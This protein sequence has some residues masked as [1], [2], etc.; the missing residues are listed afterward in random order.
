MTVRRAVKATMVALV[1]TATLAA[2]PAAAG[3]ARTYKVKAEGSGIVSFQVSPL[4]FISISRMKN[5]AVGK[6]WLYSRTTEVEVTA[7]GTRSVGRSTFLS[8][9]GDQIFGTYTGF[10]PPPVGGVGTSEVQFTYT[11]GTG[12]FTGATGM[13]TGT[14]TS[15]A[16]QL[17][18]P[19]SPFGLAY[20][21]ARSHGYITY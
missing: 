6:G 4:E 2:T 9:D 16:F 7:A 20:S 14:I 3:A 19:E 1:A 15:T 17:P 10:G 13:T 21:E 12:R 18:T 11:G 5:T 8:D